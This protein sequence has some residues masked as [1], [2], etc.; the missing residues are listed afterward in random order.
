MYSV[1]FCTASFVFILSIGHLAIASAY[2]WN[3]PC[4]AASRMCDFRFD[5]YD[6]LPTFSLSG[7]ADVPFTTRIIS[8]KGGVYLGVLNTNHIATEAIS[9][10]GSEPITDLF[11]VPP[12]VATH[13]KPLSIKYTKGSGLGH[14]VLTSSQKKALED[15]C[16]RVYF[17]SYQVLNYYGHVVE[18]K[19]HVPRSQNK[20]VV[21]RT[22]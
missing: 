19:N 10:R 11:S 7:K 6:T 3:D 1:S 16:I 18:N 13:I 17:S 4:Q 14:Q 12:L 5:S 2:E 21:F 22:N 20:C 9:P 8:K 15:K